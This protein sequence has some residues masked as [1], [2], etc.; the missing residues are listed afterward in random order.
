MLRTIRRRVPRFFADVGLVAVFVEGLP[1]DA[2]AA[3]LDSAVAA[4]GALEIL[5]VLF[6]ATDVVSPFPLPLLAGGCAHA[7][8][9]HDGEAGQRRPF[10]FHFRVS[11]ISRFVVVR[12][13]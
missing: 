4:D 6:S 13:V 2:I 7:V 3:V 10:G 9:F 12:T 1:Q 11:S 8:G 5:R